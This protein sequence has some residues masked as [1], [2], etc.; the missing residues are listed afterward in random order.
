MDAFFTAKIPLL[1]GV[2]PHGTFGGLELY[3]VLR[4]IRITKGIVTRTQG[5]D[6]E[7]LSS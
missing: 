1:A 6:V 7:M 3:H 5:I 2:G 4:V